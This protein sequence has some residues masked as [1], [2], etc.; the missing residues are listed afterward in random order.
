MTDSRAKDEAMARE[1]NEFATHCYAGGGFNDRVAADKRTAAALRSA[2]SAERSRA[3][4]EVIGELR[5]LLEVPY[6][7]KAHQLAQRAAYSTAISRVEKLR[8]GL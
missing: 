2:A 4:D 7:D 5:T 8:R 3:L 1:L 6:I